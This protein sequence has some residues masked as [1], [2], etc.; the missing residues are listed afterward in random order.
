MWYLH[1]SNSTRG[2]VLPLVA[3][4]LAVLMGFAGMAIDVGVAEYQQRQQQNATDAAAIGGAQQMIYS[5]CGSSAA[6]TAAQSDAATNGYT[7]GANGVTVQV[8]APSGPYASNNC[9]L[10]VQITNSKTPTFFM[11]LFGKS[12]LSESTTAVAAVEANNNGCIY[13]LS[14]TSDVSFSG[15]SLNA[16]HCGMLMNGTASF[17]GSTIDL[18]NI[19]YAGAKPSEAGT[20]FTEASPQP[21]LP[22]ANPC[23]EIAGCAYLAANPP[24][25]TACSNFS[26]AGYSG[27]VSA[28][29]YSS[30]SCAGCTLTLNPGLYVFTGSIS[31]S[32]VT[33]SGSGVT[34][35][36]AGTATPSFAGA[37]VSLSPPTTGNYAGVLYY[38]VPSNTSDPSFSGS[39]NNLSGLIYAP[40]AQNVSFAGASGNYVVLVFGSMSQAGTSS[41]GFGGPPVGGSLIK[42]VVLVQ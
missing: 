30:F 35:Y 1:N 14:A 37:S 13:M 21:M 28:G 16:P 2:Q 23:P 10:Q 33:M 41:G 36:A 42:N 11:K 34:L 15:D 25:S 7:N 38:Q 32:G 24:S 19:G 3:I 31:L 17:S 40:G 22:V 5:G 27:S 18:A 9:A 6:T 12:S 20:T 29:C 39:S 8:G 26:E 4:S